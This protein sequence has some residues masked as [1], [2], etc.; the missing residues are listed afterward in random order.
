MKSYVDLNRKYQIEICQIWRFLL[1]WIHGLFVF[2]WTLFLNGL[3]WIGLPGANLFVDD[4]L[5]FHFLSNFSW[6]PFVRHIFYTF[7]GK[8]GVTESLRFRDYRYAL[9]KLSPFVNE[10][11]YNFLLA[12]DLKNFRITLLR[13]ISPQ[14]IRRE[15]F[16]FIDKYRTRTRGINRYKNWS[17]AF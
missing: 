6:F 11:S 12:L 4:K 10:S 16:K 2:I 8:T 1:T 9:L 14:R 15:E 5:N 13:K 3:T 17:V 7:K